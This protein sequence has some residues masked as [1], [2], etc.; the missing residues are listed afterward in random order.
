[1]LARGKR[2]RLTY[3][4]STVI[5]SATDWTDREVV[6]YRVR[7][8]VTEPLTPEEFLRRPLIRRSRWLVIGYEPQRRA[9]RQ[10]YLGSS[11]EFAAPGM[12]RVGIYRPGGGQP[13]D[14]VSR[15]FGPTPL[16]RR[17]LAAVLAEWQS[18]RIGRLRLRVIADDLRLIAAG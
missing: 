13:V 2:L 12:L 1:M 10:F 4:A 14:L 15:Q 3:P 9:L 17:A 18:R 8:L 5:G 16:E 7:D 6:V 11:R